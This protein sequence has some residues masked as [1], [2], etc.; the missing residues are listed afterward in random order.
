MKANAFLCA[1]TTLLA[2]IIGYFLYNI[3]EGK[4]NDILC[5]VVSSLCFIITLIPL[6]AIKFELT[7]VGVNIK[8]VSSLTF[9]LL[10]IVNL[11]FA[12]FGISTPNYIIINGL[13]LVIFAMIVYKLS[14]IKNI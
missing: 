12:C 5:G 4:P 3:A 7:R 13:I 6:I 8:V 14:R 11:L 2:L 1:L 9:V 10:L